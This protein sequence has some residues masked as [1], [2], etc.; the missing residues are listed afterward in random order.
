[1]INMNYV[2]SYQPHKFTLRTGVSIP[3]PPKKYKV[4]TN[5]YNNY[6][7]NI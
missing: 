5:I 1:M 2:A 6:L 3:I 4:V 7:N